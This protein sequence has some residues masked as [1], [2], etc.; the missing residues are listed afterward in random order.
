LRSSW[1]T[2][3]L[4]L[5]VL[6]ALAPGA[7]GGSSSTDGT[8]E[9]RIV[10]AVSLADEPVHIHVSGLRSG[11]RASIEVRSTDSQG[12]K[13]LSST[14]FRADRRGQIDVDGAPALG[15]SYR[16]LWGMGPVVS[17]RPKTPPRGD[18]YAWAGQR[19]LT[20]TAHVRVGRDSLATSVFTRALSRRPIRR[21]VK[22]LGTAGFHGEYFSPV[23]VTKRPAVLAFGGAAGGLRTTRLASMLAARGYPTLALAYFRKPGLPTR[24]SGIQ[25]EYFAKALTWLGQ[26]PEVD[27]TRMFSLGISRGSEAALLLGV[28]FPRLVHGVIGAVPNNRALCPTADCVDAPWTLGGQP[29]PFT[30]EFANPHPTDTP[31][32]EIPVERIQ[33][34]IFLVC[35]EADTTWDSCGFS[36]AIM[37]R[38]RANGAT[39]RRILFAD[40]QAGHML[41]SLAP[42]QPVTCACLRRPADARARAAGWN[43]LMA[44]L[45]AVTSRG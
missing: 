34:P 45:Q 29:I 39:H 24:I 32:A 20:F 6:G 9:L 36:R 41:G 43:R 42:D 23:G 8:V 31:S 38:L 1:T 18:S 33:G 13:W 26:Q 10:P 14:T 4:G 19:P 17:M 15:G 30:N 3:L 16:G 28:H 7:A 12:T 37:Q 27:A 40:P 21:E 5:A 22:P 44:F 11:V 25:L 35:A 2:F